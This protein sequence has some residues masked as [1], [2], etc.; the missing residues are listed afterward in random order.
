MSKLS[1]ALAT[2][3][4]SA[5]LKKCL[6]SIYNYADEIV[7]YNASSTDETEE[8]LKKFP[9]IK[10]INGPNHQMF[11]HNK[12][13]AILACTGDWILQIDTD[14]IVSKPLQAEIKKTIQSTKY[15]GFWIN[16]KNYF[17]GRFLTKGGVYPD[18]TI[19]LYRKGMGSL[20]CLD[21]HEQ[22]TVKG[23][24]GNLKNDLLHYADPDFS[25]YLHRNN[26]YTSL[27]ATRLLNNNATVSFF[28][29][30]FIKPLVWFIKTYFR[31]LGLVDGFPGFVFSFFSA[32]RFP[33]IYVK[34]WELKH[35]QK[36]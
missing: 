29:Y 24:V 23:L 14:E 25:R 4:D 21:V 7:V 36:I 22:A 5:F 12:Q 32:L 35:G 11:H 17:L 13:K 16:R 3:N 6:D 2:Y 15:N 20:P 28:D 9:K 18:S 1:I 8:I 31:H 30:F 33:S 34:Y 26:R 10:I 27:E 19:R